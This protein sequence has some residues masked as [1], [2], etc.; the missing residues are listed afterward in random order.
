MSLVTLTFG[1]RST[2]EADAI[3]KG[4]VKVIKA[5]KFFGT[6]ELCIIGKLVEGAVSKNMKVVGR[7]N[8]LVKSVESN[9]GEGCCIR[10]GTKVTLMIT[11]LAKSDIKEGD[12]LCFEVIKKENCKQKG[13][14]IVA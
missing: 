1:N 11:G 12:E 7:E 10:E 4:K 3:G 2:E 13:K 6:P 14:F 8:C 5:E 9:Y